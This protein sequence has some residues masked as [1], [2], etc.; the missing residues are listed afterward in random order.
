VRF[1]AVLVVLLACASGGS[2]DHLLDRILPTVASGATSD[3]DRLMLLGLTRAATNGVPDF[4]PRRR[5]VVAATQGVSARAIPTVDSV[6]FYLLDTVTI[7]R[8]AADGG[9]FV[10]LTIY[11]P[12]IAGDTA[13]VSVGSKWA[14]RPRNEPMVLL[15]GGGCTWVYRRTG[16]SWVFGKSIGCTIS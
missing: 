11:P 1:I 15:S 9:D 14:L 4:T 8:M 10:Y 2:L 12:R 7:S 6:S 5:V 13:M 3:S 16:G